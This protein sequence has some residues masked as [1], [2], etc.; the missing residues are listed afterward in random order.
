MSLMSP[1]LAGGFLITNSTWEAYLYLYIYIYL[2]TCFSLVLLLLF[3]IFVS[4]YDI[5]I[6]TSFIIYT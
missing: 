3:L 6:N 4:L 5:H 1:I 2:C